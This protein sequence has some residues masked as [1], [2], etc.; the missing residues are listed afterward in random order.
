MKKLLKIDKDL[1]E[2]LSYEEVI[3]RYEP[4]LNKKILDYTVHYNKKFFKHDYAF[5][6]ED[7]KQI[8]LISAFKAYD[9]YDIN[10]DVLFYSYLLKQVAYGFS[11]YARD[12]IRVRKE[13][14]NQYL[15][16]EFSLDIINL[17]KDGQENSSIEDKIPNNYNLEEEI[18]NKLTVEQMLNTLTEKEK[19]I[20]K[21]LYFERKTQVEISA[22]M[23]TTQVQISRILKKTLKKMKENTNNININ[24]EKDMSKT[25]IVSEEILNY[26]EENANDKDRLLDFIK[27]YSNKINTSPSIIISILKKD[28]IR[29]EKIKNKFKRN[30]NNN[31]E[32]E[33]ISLKIPVKDIEKNTSIKNNNILTTENVISK[34]NPFSDIKI[35]NISLIMSCCEPIINKEKINLN[36]KSDIKTREDLIILKDEISKIINMYD[37]LYK[38]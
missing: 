28:P 38:I 32:N 21:L 6:K 36:I 16:S 5:S 31:V 37:Y 13:G 30:K 34:N 20:I 27:E 29:F 17:N 3:E 9:T 18:V 14:C 1:I 2:E 25:K 19:K 7:L 15:Y 8:A 33:T 26:F 11:K 24:K 22:I 12:I 35:N 23:N 10:K 4:F